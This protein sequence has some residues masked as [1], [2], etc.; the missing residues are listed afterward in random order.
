MEVGVVSEDLSREST[1]E[2]NCKELKDLC[3]EIVCD[4]LS[5]RVD[6]KADNNLENNAKNNKPIHA[7]TVEAGVV[8]VQFINQRFDDPILFRFPGES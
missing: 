5:S 4:Q 1:E 3:N 2:D 8:G 7:P 6:L